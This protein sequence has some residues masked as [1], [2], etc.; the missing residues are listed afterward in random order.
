MIINEMVVER[1]Y[2]LFNI[3]KKELPLIYL[4]AKYV[5]VR[6][7]LFKQGQKANKLFFVLDGKLLLGK[8][9]GFKRE[10]ITHILFE[11]CI[12]G[13]DVLDDSLRFK[14]YAKALTPLLVMEMDG[15]LFNLM[16]MKNLK[17]QDLVRNQLRIRLLEL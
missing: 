3:S 15:S 10:V 7:L 9:I 5:S 6:S 12:V 2:K 13:L 16:Y 4:N 8:D 17:L 14:F 11:P 1:F